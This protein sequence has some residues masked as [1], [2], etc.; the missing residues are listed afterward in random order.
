MRFGTVPEA[1]P[2]ETAQE[3]MRLETASEAMRLVDVFLDA[4]EG[5]TPEAMRLVN[6][7]KDKVIGY[8]TA[9]ERTQGVNP[10]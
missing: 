5:I 6:A 7:Q 4:P 2:F 3:A 8:N 1:M 10:P 9:P